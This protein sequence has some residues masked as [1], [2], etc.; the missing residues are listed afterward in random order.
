MAPKKPNQKKI[1]DSYKPA[2]KPS[3]SLLLKNKPTSVT[4]PKILMSKTPL[5]NKVFYPTYLIKYQFNK[6][7]FLEGYI[8]VFVRHFQGSH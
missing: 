3:G 6:L 4:V 8:H 2:P 5:E 1:T 7:I